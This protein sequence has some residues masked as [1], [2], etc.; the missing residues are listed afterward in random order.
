MSIFGLESGWRSLDASNRFEI[1]EKIDFIV[2]DSQTRFN[3]LD[4][5]T[6]DV[7]IRITTDTMERRLLEVRIKSQV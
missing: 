4:D 7:V 2:V 1:D 3:E 5:K 6:V